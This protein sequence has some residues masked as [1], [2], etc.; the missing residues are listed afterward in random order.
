[1]CLPF[2][3]LHHAFPVGGDFGES[4]VATQVRKVQNVLLE[5]GSTEANGSLE[6]LRTDALVLAHH[7]G[8][9]VHVGT[10]AFAE[11]ADGVDGTDAL[12]EEGISGK[13][14]KFGR[15]QVGGQ[16]AF[17]RNPVGIHVHELLAGSQAGF[18]L[19]TTD[20][21]AVRF[22]QVVDGSPFGEEFRIRKHFEMNA[23]V[24]TVQDA[25]H[26]CS[27][28][29]RERR[30]FDDNLAFVGNFQNIAGGLFPVLEVACLAGAM[31][32]SLGRSVHGNEDDVRFLDGSRNVRAE[33]QVATA[34][35]V[36]HIVEAGFKNRKVFA[37]PGID[38][39]LV[40]INNGHFNIRALVGNNSHGGA[41]DVAS[42]YTDNI[43]FET[44]NTTI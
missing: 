27:R 19:V 28:T 41:T 40:D 18:S 34:G 22:E 7:E 31:A 42:T 30:L 36:H 35:A 21:H 32:E 11:G 44:H 16:D 43:G 1:M 15:P 24:V 5:A 23:L 2:V 10:G 29:H 26:G 20:K 8:D 39:G 6:E 14:R 33:E 17:T 13:L 12:S 37:V 3:N 4:V 9:F 38:T 25:F